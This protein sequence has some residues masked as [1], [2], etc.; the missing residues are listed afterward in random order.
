MELTPGQVIHINLLI[1]KGKNEE[2]VEYLQQP[3][4]ISREEALKLL[5]EV[6]KARNPPI[7]EDQRATVAQ[8]GRK[9]IIIITVI[10]LV[11]LGFAVYMFVDDYQFSKHAVSVPGEVVEYS[12][13]ETYSEEEGTSKSY[14][15][16]FR[17]EIN[18]KTFTTHVRGSDP[19]GH[20]IGE[21]INILVNQA[22]PEIALPDT[23]RDRWFLSVILC[24]SSFIFLGF[25]YLMKRFG[26]T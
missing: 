12:E 8:N 17:Y 7:P 21:K 15:P 25:A 2:A 3:L 23:F 26:K 14:S 6:E 20:A 16:V 9:F 18:G 22:N 10:G 1:L 24:L 4:N 19:P 11:L 5:V 13:H